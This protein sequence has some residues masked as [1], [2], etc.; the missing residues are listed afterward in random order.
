MRFKGKS[1]IVTGAGQGIG[2]AIAMGLASEGASVAVAEINEKTAEEA[3]AQIR[4]CGG[5]A[6]FVKVDVTS[7]EEIRKAAAKV[8]AEY[9]KIDI[10]VNNV[11]FSELQPF[12]HN[13]QEFWDRTIALN[14]M[15]T[16]IFCRTVLDGMVE[17]KYGKIVNIASTAAIRGAPTQAVYAASKGGVISFTRSIAREFAEHNI[18]VNCVCPGTTDTPQWAH[19]VETLAGSAQAILDSVPMR[20]LG[21]PEEVAAPVLFLASDDASWM[22]GQTLS[23]SGGLVML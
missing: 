19:A 20:R 22:V 4:K 8:I 14:L 10:L 11:G 5:T 9:G 18:N 16:I 21:K 2:R 7:G 23:A 13:T 1:A 3:V 15:S 12:M 17:R 6:V